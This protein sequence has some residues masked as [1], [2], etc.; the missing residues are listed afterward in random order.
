MVLAKVALGFC[1]T[2]ALAGGYIFHQGVLRV[3]EDRGDGRHVH[4]WV[5]AAAVPIAMHAVPKHYLSN[6][7]EH[8]GPWMPTLRA[9]TKALRNYPEAE[10]VE[11][12]DSDQHVRIRTHQGKLFI[13]V[14]GRDENVHVVC[15]LA[16]VEDVAA[17]LE[18]IAPTV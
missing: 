3:D 8:A 1:G 13:D 18:D 16:T 9:F 14:D 11:V 7:A 12:R 4:F 2:V 6:A 5:P 17:Q 15:P 10:L